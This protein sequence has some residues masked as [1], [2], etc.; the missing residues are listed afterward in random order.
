MCKAWV[1]RSRFLLLRDVR[2]RTEDGVARFVQEIAAHP[3][4]TADVHTL[5]ITP[6][7]MHA[8]GF[9]AFVSLL[10]K[11]NSL[12]EL[13]FARLD[14]ATYPFG[15]T[16]QLACVKTRPID[17]SNVVFPSAAEMVRL[18]RSL[19]LLRQLT[20]GLLKFTRET[21]PQDC[22]RLVAPS[23]KGVNTRLDMLSVSV[24]SGECFSFL[25]YLF[26]L[27]EPRQLPSRAGNHGSRSDNSRPELS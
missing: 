1:P 2:F 4:W 20:F 15:I 8:H 9:L 7:R 26:L 13:R 11:L 5:H 22:Q 17:I 27:I 6:A 10:V 19:P 25:I 14:W 18:V 16:R 12:Q 24:S 23:H 3:H 21:T